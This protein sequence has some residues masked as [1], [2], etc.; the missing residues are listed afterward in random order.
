MRGVSRADPLGRFAC[1]RQRAEDGVLFKK[2]ETEGG[3]CSSDSR[4]WAA[5]GVE[6]AEDVPRHFLGALS[7]ES[8]STTELSGLAT[9]EIPTEATDGA[10]TTMAVR[11]VAGAHHLGERRLVLSCSRDTLS[12]LYVLIGLA[13]LA[14]A[15]VLINLSG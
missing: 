8:A 13:G 10:P 1:G 14:L 7:R 9:L 2:A 3:G 11:L 6:D 15:G 4:P 5:G 12:L